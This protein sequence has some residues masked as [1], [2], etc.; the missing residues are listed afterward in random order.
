MINQNR[1]AEWIRC[2]QGGKI[3]TDEHGALSILHTGIGK[4]Q[5]LRQS[6]TTP[7]R[8]EQHQISRR[9]VG[10]KLSLMKIVSPQLALNGFHIL[11]RLHAFGAVV[12]FHHKVERSAISS[13]QLK[14]TVWIDGESTGLQLYRIFPSEMSDGNPPLMPRHDQMHNCLGQI[15]RMIVMP[16][17]DFFEVTSSR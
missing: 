16:V 2:Q 11:L 10:G 14:R 3:A 17:A 8:N 15:I 13:D 7:S 5:D 4:A 9:I 12:Q 6:M 1:L